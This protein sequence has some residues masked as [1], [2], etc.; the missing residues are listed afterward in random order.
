MD[1]KNDFLNCFINEKV[2]V[3]QPTGFQSFNFPN[4]V[5]KLKKGTLWFE[6][7]T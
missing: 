6:T 2:F 4:H 1:M 7:S 3:E 5:F